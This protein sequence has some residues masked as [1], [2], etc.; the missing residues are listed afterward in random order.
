[1][2]GA[3]PNWFADD[4][5]IVF[6]AR[7]NDERG[8]FVA[9]RNGKNERRISGTEQSAHSPVVSPVA[10]RIAYFVEADEAETQVWIVDVD[11]NQEPPTHRMIFKTEGDC[12]PASWSPDGTTIAISVF[13]GGDDGLYLIDV[14]SGMSEKIVDGSVYSPVWRPDDS[15]HDDSQ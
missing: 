1:M 6:D 11:L 13:R 9:N 4:Q 14:E 2:W 7:R 12:W 5:Q 3:S 15:E 10:P 8:I